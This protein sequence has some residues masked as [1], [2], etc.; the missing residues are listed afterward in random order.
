MKIISL[1][2]FSILSFEL[3][4]TTPKEAFELTKSGKAVI[5]DVREE[6]EIKEGMIKH[7]IWFPLSK[8]ESDSK[9]KNEFLALTNDKKIYLY[10][11]TGKRSEKVRTILRDKK[12]PSENIG[13]YLELKDVLPSVK[14]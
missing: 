9:W 7:A 11:R 3:F 14:P 13:G 5:V 6:N 10:C 2:F 12:I 1:I 4:A 8:F